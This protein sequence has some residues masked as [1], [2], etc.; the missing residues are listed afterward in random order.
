MALSY[1]GAYFSANVVIAASAAARFGDSQIS[2]RSGASGLHRLRELVEH[3]ERLVQAPSIADDA[4]S[5]T[6][7][8]AS[9]SPSAAIADGQACGAT[10]KPRAF[11]STSSSFQLCA[12]SRMPV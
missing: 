4:S 12:L 6:P 2:R 3:V 11:K 5:G 10:A 9:R 1:L 7:R 8:R